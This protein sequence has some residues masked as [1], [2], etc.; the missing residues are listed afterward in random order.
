MAQRVNFWSLRIKL[1]LGLLSSLHF[2]YSQYSLDTLVV[3]DEI[4][5]FSQDRTG[6]VFLTFKGGAI[7]KYSAE[8]DSLISFSPEKLGDVT[9][10]EAW[11]GF[12]IFSFYE[13]FQEFALMDR[14]LTRYTR[15]RLS[16]SLENYADMCTISSDQNLW[17]FEENQLRLI[18]LNLTIRDIEIDVPLEFILDANDHNITFLREYQNLVFLVD[19]YSGIYVFDNLGNYL[20]KIPA[21]GIKNC[22]F[23]GEHLF[24]VQDNQAHDINLYQEGHKITNIGDGEYLGVL[25]IARGFLVVKKDGVIRFLETKN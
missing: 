12:Q 17:I 25:P 21:A 8:M 15:Y 9:L 13:D 16:Q 20:R 4:T 24:Y 18:K 10:L 2:A 22:S 3:E 23:S 11:H 6:N 5:A 14:F 1:F 19:E 7:T